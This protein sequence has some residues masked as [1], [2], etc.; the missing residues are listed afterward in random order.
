MVATVKPT[1]KQA[2]ASIRRVGT[3]RQV[4]G[5][6]LAIALGAAVKEGISLTVYDD[7]LGIPTTCFGQ[8]GKDVKFGQAPRELD[9]CSES[10][11]ARIDVSIAHLDKRI[12]DIRTPTGPITFSQL[13]AG[14]QE[15]LL[16]IYDNVGDGKYG[17]KDG[18]FAQKKADRVSII[19]TRLRA[20]D[21]WG[22]CM[23]ILDWKYPE[24]RGIQKR[25]ENEKT[26]CLRDLV[27]S[28]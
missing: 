5:L 20:G 25:R 28:Q 10:L 13:T 14:E 26:T 1:Q 2:E 8:T 16:S 19:V 11:L 7:G 23:G 21:R 15:G 3:K 27:V 22:A 24:W 6:V 12:G 17:V 9:A 18:F 4:K